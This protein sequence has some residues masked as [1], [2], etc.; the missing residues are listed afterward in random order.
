[1][2][3]E[4]PDYSPDYEEIQDEW[5]AFR[6][7]LRKI[8]TYYGRKSA[9]TRYRLVLE[10][11]DG[12]TRAIYWQGHPPHVYQTP[13]PYSPKISF[14]EPDPLD[15]C[16]PTTLLVREYELYS[17]DSEKRVAWYRERPELGTVIGRKEPLRA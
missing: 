15:F 13:L 10:T 17:I 16:G 12:F 6:A 2:S 4:L 1:M 11:A 8:G 14:R 7:A 9:V 3:S 5:T